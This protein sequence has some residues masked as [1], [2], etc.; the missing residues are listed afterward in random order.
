LAAGAAVQVWTVNPLVKVFPEEA[1]PPSQAA[2]APARL[3]ACRNEYE[4]LQLAVRARAGGRLTLRATG[5]TGPGG[6]RLEAP[7]I[8]RVGYVPVDFPVGYA[9]SQLPTYYRLLPAHR[10]TDGWAGEWPDPLLP[11]RGEALELA[12]GRTQPLWFDYYVPPQAPPGEYS[13]QVE[14]RLGG[15][16]TIVPVR[17]RVWPYV[18][19]K[20]KSLSVIYDLRSGPLGDIM[21]GG[22][23]WEMI[24]TWCRF[25]ARYNISPGIIYPE[26]QI[27]YENGQL[28]MDFAEFDRTCALLFDELGCRVAYT[29][30]FFYAFGWG[31]PPKKLFGHEP[32][33]PEWTAIFQGGLQQLFAHLRERGW[34]KYFVY[35]ASD[36]P[37]TRSEQVQGNLARVCDL[38][39]A[40][41]P[42]LLI[43]SSTWVHLT[44][45]DDHLNLW[46]IG[47]HGSFPLA[48]LEKRRQAGDRFWFTTDGHMCIDTPYLAIERLLP[49]LCCKYGVEGYEFWGVSW[50][51]YDPWQYGWHRYIS[52]SHE[53]K[54]FYWV[55]YPNGDGYLTYPG[56]AIGQ[57]EPVPSIRLVA[58]REGVEDYELFAAART[59][60]SKAGGRG[61]AVA[62]ALDRALQLVQIPNAGGRFSTSLMPNPDAV[63]AA[64]VEVGEALA[65]LTAP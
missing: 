10:G 9:S 49:W 33:T 34:D 26:P 23:R 51:T 5:L 37:D 43:Y 17:L 20:R 41:V 59:L 6:A 57:R 46:G 60:A 63:L 27:K 55:R 3:Y 47:P 53:G 44:R 42:G 21:A 15:R 38:A 62:A 48:D 64:R 58:A 7:K 36:E 2:P 4:P 30:W 31:Y 28:S 54:T 24:Q 22:D 32:F 18:L 50:W 1:P 56:Q 39:R 8:F 19:P 65:R 40:A 35:Y 45:L 25:L 52:Q 12:A 14:L 29:P 11:V 61:R 16:S 13:G